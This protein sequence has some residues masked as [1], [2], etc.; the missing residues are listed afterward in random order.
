[1]RMYFF[2][3]F[4]LLALLVAGCLFSL[5]DYQSDIK[6]GIDLEG[7]TELLYEIPLEDVPSAQRSSVAADVKDVIARRFD[8]YGLKEI[9]VAIAGSNRLQIQLPGFDNEELERLKGQIEKA[10]ELNIHLVSAAEYSTQT[11]I[12]EIEAAMVTRQQAV[13]AYN[14]L[15]ADQQD[16]LAFPKELDRLVV[17]RPAGD[18]G[19]RGQPVVVENGKGLKV[20]GSFIQSAQSTFD[21]QGGPAVGFTFGGAGSTL[22][23]N[24][25]GENINSSLAIVLDGLAVSVAT[26]N[27]AIYSTGI[28]SGSFTND[29]VADIVTMLR[30]GSLPTK[31]ILKSQQTVGSVLGKESIDRGTQSMVV[32]FLLVVVF[33]LIFYRA[34]GLVANMSL[35]LNLL[36]VLTL[37]VI[38]RNTLTFPGMAG[39][40]LTV[41]MAVD[42][43]I[44][45]FERIREER[46][47]GKELPAAFKAGFQ[48]AF[49]TIFDANLTT[50]I[51]AFMLFQFGTGAVK[52]FAIV[53]SIGIFTSFF[54]SI[55]VS[56][57]LISALIHSGAVKEL[58]M[59]RLV[60]KTRIDFMSRRGIARTASIV[61][62]L[63]GLTFL[64]WRGGQAMG[65]DF[66]G[67]TK[68]AVNL[69]QPTSEALL[70]EKMDILANESSSL[71]FEDL[72]IQVLGTADESGA[73][74]YSLKTKTLGSGTEETEAFK[75]AVEELLRSEG[76]L[77]PNGI[78]E[79]RIEKIAGVD[80]A[81]DT[82]Q[83]VATLNAVRGVGDAAQAG[84]TASK[85]EQDIL[86]SGFPVA[87]VTEVS[88]SAGIVSFELRSEAQADSTSA[89]ALQGELTRKLS[90]FE[91]IDFSEPFP[92]FSSIGGK[93]AQDMQGKTFVALMISF[94]PIVFYISIRFELIFGLAAIVALL[95]DILFTLG[96]L[97]VGDFLLGDMLSL[98]INLPV[99]AAL[100]TVV[101]YSLNDTIV[102]FDRIRENLV[103][104]RRDVNYPD[105]VNR[106]INQTLA[107]T[108]LTSMTTFLVVA[109]LLTYGGEGLHAFAFALCIGVLVGTYSS[110]FVASPTLIH[111]QEKARIRREQ[112][113][114]EAAIKK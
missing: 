82:H 7:G 64:I 31:P 110:I 95:H 24:L 28:I 101:G 68:L 13:V 5:R 17:Y 36:L 73:T 108:L 30:A 2:T 81:A 26:I 97:A 91:E 63:G 8:S 92:E 38:F 72:Q 55:F 102:I 43:N 70:R 83:M 74:R 98:K 106:S 11:V 51:T 16:P 85:V 100:L 104:A 61:L 47:R 69:S 12:T 111:L 34:A 54:C 44:L 86:A 14:S 112:V 29:E 22:F 90:T 105:I 48:R 62:V 33:M 37:L 23:G 77:A 99:V 109:I 35:M 78:S 87:G 75:N 3:R 50:L 65:I 88:E 67:G 76:L 89:L 42:A 40:L 96:A 53:L 46:D 39:L 52:G 6:K 56:R 45:I 93:V 20:S 10:G 9:S 41:G 107:R 79:V 66:T 59:T 25:T 114:A 27:D 58:S 103:D 15:P 4:T 84:L 19:V 94:F 32:G 80:G 18:D 21:Q 60:S 71:R 57:L 1:M 49:W 113:I